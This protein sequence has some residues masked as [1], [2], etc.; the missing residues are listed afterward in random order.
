MAS[1]EI[2]AAVR[3]VALPF[4]V[5]MPAQAA[6][7]ASLAAEP[8]LLERVAHL[9]T[10]R[11]ELLTGLRDLGFAVPDAQGNFVWLPSGART[12]AYAQAF[13]SA[14]LSVRPYAAGRRPGRDPDH[15]RRARG[16]RAGA[17]GGGHAAPGLTRMSE[18]DRAGL[19]ARSASWSCTTCP[20]GRSTAAGWFGPTTASAGSARPHG[21]RLLVRGARPAAGTGLCPAQRRPAAIALAERIVVDGDPLLRRLN[22]QSLRWRGT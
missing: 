22:D 7:V 11:D 13:G 21:R 1:P 2:A 12:A 8:A 5:S 15:R 20:G 19:E 17:G 10:A 6:A 14:A 3:A 18:P 4:G 9:V 16:Q